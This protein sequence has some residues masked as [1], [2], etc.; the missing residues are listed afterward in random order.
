MSIIG[1]PKPGLAASPLIRG[2]MKEGDELAQRMAG[3]N[4]FKQTDTFKAM[5]PLDAHMLVLQSEAM[6]TYLHILTIRLA[7]ANDAEANKIPDTATALGGKPA[8]I[9]PN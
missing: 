7:R 8:I 4:A 1:A 2:I 9:R 6:Q 5:A 3:I